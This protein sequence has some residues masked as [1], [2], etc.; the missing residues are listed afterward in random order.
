MSRPRRIIA[1][2]IA[3][4]LVCSSGF[5]PALA[6]GLISTER[7][8]EQATDQPAS[9]AAVRVPAA[10]R[11]ALASALTRAGAD[12]S[13]LH[14]RLDSLTDAEVAQLRQTL[15]TAPAGGLWFVPFLVVAAVIGVLIGS[16]EP[17][18]GKPST[19]LFG[20]PQIATAP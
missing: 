10:E 5:N 18:A 8:A 13:Q 12:A 2:S 17:S 7:V 1:S 9:T 15:D 19:N 16:R 11:E 20:Y 6:G 4:C 3:L 14:S